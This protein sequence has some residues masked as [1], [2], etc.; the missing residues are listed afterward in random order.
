MQ[1]PN[2]LKKS[3]YFNILAIIILCCVGFII[4]SNTFH[5]SFH[6]DDE[7]S[8][9]NNFAIKNILNLRNIWDF[10]PPR[11]IAHLSLSI[12]YHFHQLDVFGYHLVNLLI[13]IISAILVFYFILLTFST[14]RMKG[15]DIARHANIVAIFIASIFLTHPIQTQAVTY[16]IQR[17]TSLATLFYLAS[18][19][20]YIKSRLSEE[21]P[22]HSRIYYF[23][24]LIVA[25]IA[26]FT[27]EVTLTLPFAV[28]LYEVSFFKVKNRINLKKLIPF[29]ITL[30]IIPLTML[31]FRLADFQEMRIATEPITPISSA[32]YLFTQF[33]VM[34]SYIRLLLL[35]INQNLDYNYPISTTLMHPPTLTSFLLLIII[36]IVAIKVSRKYKLVSFSIFWFFLTLLPESSIIPIRD[37]IFEHRLYLPMVGYSL[38]LVSIFY[39]I[40]SRNFFKLFI[41]LPLIIVV[42]FSVLTYARNFVWKD[43]LTLWNDTVRKSPNKA[44]P[45]NNRGNASLNKSEFDQAIL[46]FNKAIEIN[47]RYAEAYDNLG[48][49][50]QKKG[51]LKKALYYFNKAIEI[52]PSLAKAYCNRGVAY[53]NK[54]DLT[55]AISDFNKAIEID[56]HYAEACYNRGLAYQNK[57]EVNQAILD[58]NKAIEVN[59]GYTKAYNNRGNAYQNKGEFGQAISD[60]NKA[61]EIDP[62]Y[63][64]VY[65][66]RGIAYQIKGEFDQAISDYDK[67]IEINPGHARAYNNR[68]NVFQNK[69]EFDQAISD[70]NKAIEIN[71]ELVSAYNNRA[72]AYFEKEAYEESWEDVYKARVLGYNFNPGFIEQLKKAAGSER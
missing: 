26:M 35:P 48:D 31:V 65:Y 36:L 10:W 32:N 58:Y 15:E 20:F 64:E 3:S 47:P 1:K 29:F 11:F 30:L 54:G 18:L 61:V 66:N 38:F 21:K 22:L 43:E 42:S 71:P 63:G 7:S 40:F 59:P 37:V 49:A 33:R 56:S 67:A 13:H 70:Y 50:Y 62:G 52:D 39:Y 5:S 16:I 12:N 57:G 45:Y 9:V 14:P 72:V 44:R 2:N 17:L 25:A 60:Y 34:V 51:D 6:F 27:K 23:L 19:I 53:K 28:L 4:Y 69:G 41:I 8:I 24:S 68:G 55:Q 46:D